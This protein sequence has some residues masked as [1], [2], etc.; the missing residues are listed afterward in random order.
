[1]VS[2][3]FNNQLPESDRRFSDAMKEI[4][5]QQRRLEEAREREARE[6]SEKEERIY[7]E[8]QMDIMG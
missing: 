3:Q 4:E 5:D 1:M 2:L 6:A 8:G 7:R